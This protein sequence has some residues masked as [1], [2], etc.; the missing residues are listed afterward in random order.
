[1]RVAQ[2]EDLVVVRVRDGR[3]NGFKDRKLR[4]RHGDCAER[5]WGIVMWLEGS[6][7]VVVRIVIQVKGVWGLMRSRRGDAMGGGAADWVVT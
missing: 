5:T 6:G 3:V 2:C 7:V 4:G 1:M